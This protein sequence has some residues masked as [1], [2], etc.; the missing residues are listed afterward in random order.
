M[1]WSEFDI[2]KELLPNDSSIPWDIAAI[3]RRQGKWQEALGDYR[4]IVRMDPQNA[5]IARDLFYVYCAMRDWPNAQATAKRLL[6]LTPD[7]MN[8]KAQVGYADFW[9]TGSTARLKNELASIPPGKDPD[10]AVTAFRIDVNMIDR[11]AAS[12]EKALACFAAR[13]IFVLQRR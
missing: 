3:K 11:D 8:A 2:A 5:N 7:S 9:A 13:H 12:A 1:R 4:Q 10:G 6:E